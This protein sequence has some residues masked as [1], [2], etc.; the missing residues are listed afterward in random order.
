MWLGKWQIP[1]TEDNKGSLNFQAK[2]AVSILNTFKKLLEDLSIIALQSRIRYQKCVRKN[3]C[4]ASAVS[5]HTWHFM[6]F[7]FNFS[8]LIYIFAVPSLD[9]ARTPSSSLIMFWKEV[10][11][12]LLT[13]PLGK[14]A[15]W[16]LQPE[17]NKY[18]CQIKG[19]FLEIW[20][21]NTH[22]IFSK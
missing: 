1:I 19:T 13:F 15:L 14:V 12:G 17:K 18:S 2:A 8:C 22:C 4:K 10:V 6:H 11:K 3:T 20:N 7:L 21:Q 16:H 9:T 5:N